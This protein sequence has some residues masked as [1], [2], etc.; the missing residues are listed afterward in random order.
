MGPVASTA[1][2]SSGIST[3]KLLGSPIASVSLLSK[4]ASPTFATLL[5]KKDRQALIESYIQLK[6]V[7]TETRDRHLQSEV[8]RSRL[9]RWTVR[10]ADEI[11]EWA[12]DYGQNAVKVEYSETEAKLDQEASIDGHS[13]GVAEINDMLTSLVALLPASASGGSSSSQT[14]GAVLLDG[15]PLRFV[16]QAHTLH[17]LW[18]LV[19][20]TSSLGVSTDSAVDSTDATERSAAPPFPDFTQL[21]DLATVDQVGDLKVLL[22]SIS[23]SQRQLESRLDPRR[24]ESRRLEASLQVCGRKISLHIEQLPQGGAQAW[25]SRGMAMLAVVVAFVLGTLVHT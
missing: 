2:S 13:P 19:Q 5:H 18:T 21:L 4:S 12:E 16:E 1:S 14:I 3:D 7:S 17:T 6:D 15:L 25:G 24:Y 22:D 20:R 8:L 11:E 10:L 23:R 9:L